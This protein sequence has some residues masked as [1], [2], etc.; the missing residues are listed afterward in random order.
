[1]FTTAFFQLGNAPKYLVENMWTPD[2][3]NAKYPRL[4]DVKVQNNKWASAMWIVDGSYLR[5]KSVQLGYTL[6]ESFVGKIGVKSL[7]VHASGGNLH[8][9]T[10]FPYLDPEAPDVSN[11]FYPQQRVYQ[12]G[13]DVKF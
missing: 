13:I 12:F 9:W 5:I 2:N 7:R 3:R 4:S 1:E 6:P 8:T 11:G 10:E